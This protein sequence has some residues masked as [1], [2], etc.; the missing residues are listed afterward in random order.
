MTINGK[1]VS[2][3]LQNFKLAYGLALDPQGNIHVAANVIK[4]FTPEGIYVRSYGDVYVLKGPTG[5]AVDEEGYSIVCDTE[6]NSLFIF[7][8]Q[9]NNVSTIGNFNQ[10]QGVILD[11]NSGSLYVANSGANNV[12]KYAM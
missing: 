4:V 2:G 1:N 5:V 8:P 11:P 3:D 12:L 10:P 7:D 6:R 9:G